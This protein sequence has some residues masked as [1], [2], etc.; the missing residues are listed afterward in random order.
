VG[1]TYGLR[2]GTTKGCW[3][4]MSVRLLIMPSFLN[5][6]SLLC[7]PGGAGLHARPT[8]KLLL[9]LGLL[10]QGLDVAAEQAA[11]R[12]LEPES[13]GGIDEDRGPGATDA[14]TVADRGV[15]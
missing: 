11:F 1:E 7:S 12:A 14:Q 15:G 10:D 8:R 5:S 13:A 3:F 2:F 6:P 4:A 9:R